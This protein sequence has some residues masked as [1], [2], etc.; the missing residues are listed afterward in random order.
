M[1][2]QQ[3]GYIKFSSNENL[4]PQEEVLDFHLKKSNIR[5]GVPKETQLQE[6]RIPLVPQAAGL[7]ISNG[8]TVILESGA[9]KAANFSDVDFSEVGAQIV[10]TKQ[11]V[12]KTDVIV[13]VAP[14]S[15]EETEFLTSQQTLISSVH[16]AGQSRNYFEKL[17]A[18]KMTAIAFEYIKDKAGTFPVIR[19]MSEIVGTASIFIANE[20]L[21]NPKYGKGVLLGGFPGITPSEV[22]IIG[23]GA[24]AE[25]AS[26]AALGLGALVKVFDNS[27]Y[28]L[29]RLQN[30]LNSRIYTSILEPKVLQK[31]LKTADVLI[32]AIHTSEGM[33]PCIVTEEMVAQMKKGSVIIDISIDQGGCIETSRITSHNDPVFMVH[34]VTHY[35]VPNIASKF[36]RTASYALSNFLTPIL[37][38]IGEAGG[39]ERMLKMDY[40]LRQGSYLF[41]GTLTKS[42][43]GEYFTLPYQDIEL[44]IAAFR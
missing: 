25:Y 10:S 31:A 32:G 20:Y 41:N 38:R 11:E 34:D 21:V 8:N 40:G 28:K 24:V 33:T 13:K 6:N 14:P 30:L 44:L 27:I 18:R 23:S 9:G 15:L 4:L 39:I 7:L 36:P 2:S 12:F 35:C 5:I 1:S 3:N 42:Y 22:V 43:I 17:M 19:A 37:I 26:R 16:L 29:R